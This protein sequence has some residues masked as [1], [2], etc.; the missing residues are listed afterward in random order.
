MIDFNMIVEINRI[1]KENYLDYSIHNFKGCF[2]NRVYLKGNGDLDKAINLINKY[3]S[4][5]NICLKHISDLDFNVEFKG[6]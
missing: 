2:D 1:L 6:L 5:K 3:L 4:H